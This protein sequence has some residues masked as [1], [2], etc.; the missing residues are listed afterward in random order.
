MAAHQLRFG[1]QYQGR[2]S[3][4]RDRTWIDESNIGQPRTNLFK[5]VRSAMIRIHQH[6]YGKE[7]SI[8]RPLAILIDEKFGNGNRAARS[9]CIKYPRQQF[10]AVLF[11]FAVQDM[12]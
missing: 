4:R 12:A 3:R 9:Q 5:G 11:T 7:E 8:H 6:V 2:R 10:A 1:R